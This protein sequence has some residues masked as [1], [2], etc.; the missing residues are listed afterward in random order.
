MYKRID[1][2]DHKIEIQ[3]HFRSPMVYLDHWA[4]NDLSLNA[5]LRKRFVRVM[6]DKGG[7]FR[8]SVVNIT[9]LSKQADKAQV[10]SILDMI[11]SVE[12]CGFINIDPGEVIGKE[13]ILI[14]DPASI[15]HVKNPSAELD[16]VTAHVI[17]NNYPG[18]WHVSD[19]I[20]SV[21][22]EMPSK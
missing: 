3:E 13:N 20:K 17:A 7:T 16:L 15:F 1:Y 2:G 6:N 18:R 4:L 10:D 11:S 8:L 21:V 14:S 19:I 5:E 9:E 12:D 22:G